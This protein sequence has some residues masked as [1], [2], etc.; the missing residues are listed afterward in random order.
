M[1]FDLTNIT[2]VDKHASSRKA[3]DIE[4][5][6][7]WPTYSRLI[8][9]HETDKDGVLHFSNY[10]KIAEEAMFTGFRH[11]N[12]PF[13]GSEYSV[14]MVNA[15]TRY[16]HPI[17]FSHQINIFLKNHDIKRVKFVLTFEFINSNGVSLAETQLTLVPIIVNERR[18]VPL[19]ADFKE[20][21]K[22]SLINN[23]TTT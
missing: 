7:F 16:I 22:S 23:S 4:Q 10:F 8:H 20:S 17:K 12:G 18:A 15:T 2:V 5:P 3:I 9:I 11:L 14:A 1:L 21:L 6:V 19:P 13:D